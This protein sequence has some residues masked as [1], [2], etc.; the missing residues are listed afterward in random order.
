MKKPPIQ[1]V[2]VFSIVALIPLLA[3]GCSGEPR[4]ITPG[5]L[6]APGKPSAAREAYN[7]LIQG[8]VSGTV[9]I[10]GTARN[11]TFEEPASGKA[12]EVVTKAQMATGTEP[13]D[14][15]GVPGVSS[16]AGAEARVRPNVQPVTRVYGFTLHAEVSAQG[17]FWREQVAGVCQKSRVEKGRAQAEAAGQIELHFEAPPGITDRLVVWVAGNAAAEDTVEVAHAN[18][19]LL[20]LTR[21]PD[22]TGFVVELPRSGTYMVSARI[23]GRTESVGAKSRSTVSKELQ[24]SVQSLRDALSL[25]PT[26]VLT[27]KTQVPVP[28]FVP[29]QDLDR[30]LH[31]ALLDQ[32]DGKFWPCSLDQGCPAQATQVFV[33]QPEWHITGGVVA[34]SFRLNQAGTPDSKKDG[35]SGSVVL[36]GAP[37]VQGQT[38]ALDALAIETRSLQAVRQFLSEA[39]ARNLVTAVQEKARVPMDPY[40]K[41]T[42]QALASHLPTR[43]GG[44]CLLLDTDHLTL[45][46]V[47]VT[48]DPD[49]IVAMFQTTLTLADV[50][51]C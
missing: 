14:S 7:P 36:T 8:K 10:A 21:L 39:Y 47:A 37:T 17:G 46:S 11:R 25:G 50:G 40:L 27:D 49:G 51:R 29:L 28:V 44:V 16:Q 23:E 32:T 5:P 30:E 24:V 13:A 9:R 19:P 41:Q 33:E 43:W 38:F 15:C 22:K 35:V 34:L 6:A 12:N 4:V 48:R 18:G 42:L 2:F 20:P 45:K 3:A 31:R 26:N 1:L